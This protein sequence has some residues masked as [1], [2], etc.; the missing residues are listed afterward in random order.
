MGCV[1]ENRS[2]TPPT[3]LTERMDYTIYC[4]QRQTKRPAT[5]SGGPRQLHFCRG[6][7]VAGET[8]SG[9]NI[10]EDRTHEPGVDLFQA[11]HR[12]TRIFAPGLAGAD[13]E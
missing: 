5:R 9:L 2:H 3:A 6:S 7:V 8:A 4:T 12:G 13:D 1:L 10:G 11:L